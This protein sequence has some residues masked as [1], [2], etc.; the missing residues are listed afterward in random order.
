MSTPVQR[1]ILVTSA[2]PYA[3]GSLHLGHMLEYVQSDI[4]VRFQQMRGH[5]CYHICGSDAHGT[6]IMLQAEKLNI[7]PEALVSKIN[8]EHK[9][10]LEDFHIALD[11]F[12]TTH[13]PEN[14]SLATSIYQKLKIKGDIAVR[15]IA[16]AYDPIKNMFLPDRYV[17]GSCPKCQAPD[18]Y[19]DS[20]EQ[21]GA[22]YA[23]TDLKNA[24]STVSGA[25]PILKESEHYFF[26]LDQYTEFLKTW[27]QTSQLQAQIIHKLDEWF[28]AGLKEWDIS[29][30][31]PYFGFK[32][33]DT[34]N[35]YFYVWLDAP[36][37]YM[38]SFKNYIDTN[39]HK[40]IDFNH[41][42]G[43]SDA[44][45]HP[46]ELYHFIGKD[47][48]YFHTLF[49]PAI[50]HGSNYRT[51]TAIFAHGFL[52]ING[53]KM[54]KS[55]GT[56]ITA[57]QYLDHL[58]PEYIRY[59]F[60]AK[61]SDGVEDLDLNFE[62]FTAR[63]NSDLVGKFVNIASRCSG[64]IH[65]H[66][67]GTL[68]NTLSEPNLF[69]QFTNQSESIAQAFE[70]RQYSKAIR[71]IMSL[72]DEANRYIDEQKPWLLIKDPATMSAAQDACTMG[73]NLFKILTGY[74]KPILPITAHNAEN[75]LNIPALQWDT[76]KSPLL[77]HSINVFKSLK[78]RIEP[79]KITEMYQPSMIIN[80]ENPQTPVSSSIEPI[81]STIEYDDFAKID[82]RIVKIIKAEAVEGAEKLLKLTLDL[83]PELGPARQVF[84]GIKSAYEPKDL[85]GKLTVMV[86]NLAPRKM[87]FG[88]SEGMVL[89]A[90]PGGK[91]LWILHP[92]DGAQPGMRVK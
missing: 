21:C 31:A 36:I 25:P 12:Y 85:E 71:E 48:M 88:L 32:I 79:H 87:R 20:C 33:P 57:R 19:G 64:F 80:N 43:Q 49:W 59:Y 13:S 83:G 86:A 10:D 5:T 34:T 28:T 35:K 53:Q 22:H 70:T 1:E 26:K 37:G 55:R 51:P 52:T 11:H 8:L 61:L 2:L 23:P 81:F 41:Y 67:E 15:T 90:G 82:L 63:V 16:Q 7:T 17:K 39:P 18:Q 76:L 50:L 27:T 73:L 38:A 45:K 91:D 68:A 72:T 6:P 77:N 69:A 42:W 40:G 30:D 3:N 56:F 65:K 84:A 24:I 62:D 66:F 4:W 9:K 74:L 44:A 75:F 60:A 46:T 29:R 14:E 47:I 78:Q 54:S 58:D 92:Q 89:A